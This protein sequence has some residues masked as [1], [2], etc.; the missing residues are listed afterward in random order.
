[1][2]ATYATAVLKNLNIAAMSSIT[3]P[4]TVNSIPAPLNSTLMATA[5]H[6]LSSTSLEISKS[7]DDY[8][9]WFLPVVISSCFVFILIV[10]FLILCWRWKKGAPSK[11][12]IPIIE[13]TVHEHETIPKV[14]QALNS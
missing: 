2:N 1:M 4:Y 13:N 12:V 5:S 9:S 14:S 7:D 11:K 3:A 6:S 8:P 10:L